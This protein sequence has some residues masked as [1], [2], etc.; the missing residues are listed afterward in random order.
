MALPMKNWTVAALIAAALVLI[1]PL[2][3]A[4]VPAMPDYP[5]RLAGF[6]LIGGMRSSFYTVQWAAVPNL[7]AETLVP[8]L[9]RA[10]PPETAVRIFLSAAVAM[11]VAGPALIHR[12]LYGRVG[13]MP[14]IAAAFA[15][16]I[17]FMWGFFNYYF[18]TGLCLIVFAAWI[19][20]AGWRR[21]LRLLIF[22]FATIV[23]YFSH[24]LGAALF[25]FLVA[26]Y[27]ASAKSFSWRRPFIEPAILA[28]P[29]AVLFF[30][31][32]NGTGGKI[33]FDLA[34]TFLRRIESIV[35]MR[36]QEP[37]YPVLAALGIFLA[38]GF[39]R[40]FL[41]IHRRMRAAVA[42][43]WLGAFLVPEIAMGGWG[44]HLRFPAVAA[45]LLFAASEISLPRQAAAFA[46]AL[47]LAVL[48]WLSISLTANWRAFDRSVAEFRQALRATPHGIRLM[49][50]ID[51]DHMD[52]MPKALYWHLGEFAIIDRDD[53][54][55]LMFTTEGQHI[56]KADPAVA[57][58]S[59]QTAN[60]GSP[61]DLAYLRALSAGDDSLPKIHEDLQY[62]LHFECYYDA[63]VLIHISGIPHDVP[64]ALKIRHRGSFFSLYDVMKPAG[65]STISA[66]RP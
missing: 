42:L 48:G 59:A 53:A 43:L 15:Y 29:V 55:T 27:E 24:V 32:M 35:Q 1:L 26:C 44:L 36:F 62:M 5:A 7:A 37:A 33:E 31:Q 56:V 8:L 47:V 16:N 52:D 46:G 21:V 25:L 50:A 54:T 14:L 30:L 20:S 17:N 40:S 23:L 66:M 12:A 19:A 58:H 34:G 45:A 64:A 28:A 60:E 11:W 41:T 65:C 18:S 22:A 6:Y 4:G 39:W 49:T 13:Q 63:A 51:A 57:R 61:P 10:M 2:W 38:A 3:C 9:A